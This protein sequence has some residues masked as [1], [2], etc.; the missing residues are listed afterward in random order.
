[1]RLALPTKKNVLKWTLGVVG[2]IIVG[3]LGSGVWQSLLG[4][5]IHASTR[6][7]LDVASLGLTSY[8]NGVYQQI[9]TDNQ[10][11]I[12]IE[13]LYLVT[14]IYC[15]LIYA[16]IQAVFY[17]LSRLRKRGERLLEHMSGAPPESDAAITTDTL[18]PELETILR[19][20]RTF[21]L[22]MYVSTLFVGAVLASHF[23]TL[24][25]LSYIA[26]AD[27]HYHQVLHLASPYLD[28]HE[29]TLVESEF[30]QL[31]NRDD[32]V[33]LLSRLEGQCKAHGQTVPK[34]DAW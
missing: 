21:R 20:L 14:F 19:S 12:T 28:A 25:R 23:V 8:K 31:S 15:L 6:W 33:R 4:P 17:T 11:R 24:A 22:A 2:A 29:Q 30:A 1:M 27:A 34:F 26:S 16:A 18:R 5:A 7:L 3:A 32:Y 13:T 9:A 10:F